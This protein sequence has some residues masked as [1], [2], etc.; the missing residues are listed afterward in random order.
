MTIETV[1]TNAEALQIARN[2]ASSENINED[3]AEA[4]AEAWFDAGKD[5]DASSP[6]DLLAYLAKRFDKP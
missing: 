5:F 3:L 6:A 1:K 4:Y 2:F